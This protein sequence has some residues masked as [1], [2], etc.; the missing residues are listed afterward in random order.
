MRGL[1]NLH[2][3]VCPQCGPHA[4]NRCP[5]C[6]RP[7]DHGTPPETTA[8]RKPAGNALPAAIA[9]APAPAPRRP[10][11]ARLIR[12]GVPKGDGIISFRDRM[13]PTTTTGDLP[14]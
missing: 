12:G 13:T 3:A 4:G 1:D 5:R 7:R 6:G 8:R 14:T 9:T 10:S 11:K 2:I